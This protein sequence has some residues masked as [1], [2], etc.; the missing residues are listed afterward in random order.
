MAKVKASNFF[1]EISS[2]LF[3]ASQ[4]LFNYNRTYSDILLVIAKDILEFSKNASFEF[5]EVQD[6]SENNSCS[7]QDQSIDKEIDEFVEKIKNIDMLDL[8]SKKDD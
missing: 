1:E 8:I 2:N 6:S 7:I 5:V 3:I 4:K